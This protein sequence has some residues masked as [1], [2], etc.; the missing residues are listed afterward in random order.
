MSG[1]R[2]SGARGSEAR[3]SEARARGEEHE[4][5]VSKDSLFHHHHPNFY[6]L[7]PRVTAPF[8]GTYI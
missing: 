6:D 8:T 5:G 3:A 7:F 4:K 1:V 2:A